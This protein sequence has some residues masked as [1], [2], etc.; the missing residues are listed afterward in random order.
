MPSYS[1]FIA[2]EVRIIQLFENNKF[3]LCS[4]VIFSFCSL[5]FD[6][7]LPMFLPV[8]SNRGFLL[9]KQLD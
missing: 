8:T 5:L 4:L 9:Y 1:K 6:G 3:G 2:D 7:L